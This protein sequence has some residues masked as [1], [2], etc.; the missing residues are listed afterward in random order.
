MSSKQRSKWSDSLPTVEKTPLLLGWRRRVQSQHGTMTARCRRLG[1]DL[2]HAK[3]RRLRLGSEQPPM[4]T[5]GFSG[6]TP[7]Q[8]SEAATRS[9]SLGPAGSTLCS[10]CEGSPAGW[11]CVCSNKGQSQFNPTGLPESDPRLRCVRG[12]FTQQAATPGPPAPESQAGPDSTRGG[13]AVLLGV[14]I[15]NKRTRRSA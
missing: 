4:A 3:A 5:P 14:Q 6:K 7:G 13:H 1:D 2:S 12:S 9:S 10:R 8:L 11:T 15:L